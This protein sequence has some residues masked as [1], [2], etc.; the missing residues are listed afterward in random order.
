MTSDVLIVM[1]IG[2]AGGIFGGV[3]LSWLDSVL[4]PREPRGSDDPM[5]YETR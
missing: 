3:F 5:E 4:H 1:G 2:L